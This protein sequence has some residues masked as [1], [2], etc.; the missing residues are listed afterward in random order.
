MVRETEVSITLYSQPGCT[1]CTAIKKKFTREGL[2]EG[3][4]FT[5]IDVSLP[6]N[7]GDYEA[8]KYLGYLR[9]PVTMVNDH[10]FGGFNPDEV[11]DAIARKKRTKL[12]VVP[13]AAVA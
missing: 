2:I 1:Q 7:A 11:S 9:V 10:H 4:D 5:V 13:E 3:E 12:Q 8:I 6:E